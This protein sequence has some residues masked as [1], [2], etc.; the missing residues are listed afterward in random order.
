MK[1]PTAQELINNCNIGIWEWVE[2]YN[3]RLKVLNPRGRSYGYEKVGKGLD[4]LKRLR[5]RL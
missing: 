3:Y 4:A 5:S 2:W 1:Q